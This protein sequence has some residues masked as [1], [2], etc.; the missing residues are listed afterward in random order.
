MFI[1][2]TGG[3]GSGKSSTLK[4]FSAFGWQTIDADLL[5]H[6]FYNDSK[7]EIFRAMHTRWGNKILLESG[8]IDR[9]A[10]GKLVFSDTDSREWL[11]ALLHPAILQKALK[12]YRN[13]D[14]KETVFDVPLLYE[15]GWEG[16]FDKIIAVW[17]ADKIR[18][19]RL[20]KRGMSKNDIRSRDNAQLSPDLKIEKADYVII[21]NGNIDQLKNQC[22]IIINILNRNK[23]K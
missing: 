3:M 21:N 8:R 13:S 6:S 20:K 12:I 1:G 23:K 2:L 4:F 15:A 18:A 11:N 19:E 10:V 22:K 9:T 7:S 16:N 5:C 14:Q 17:T